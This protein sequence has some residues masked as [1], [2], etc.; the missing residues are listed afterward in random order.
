MSEYSGA[1]RG[2][3]RAIMHGPSIFDLFLVLP[4]AYTHDQVLL[5][6]IYME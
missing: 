4:I 1:E 5:L 3:A 2:H 6:Y